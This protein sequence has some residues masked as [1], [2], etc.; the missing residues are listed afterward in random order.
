MIKKSLTP[1]LL[2]VALNSSVVAD[3]TSADVKTA[4]GK[5]IVHQEYLNAK[6]EQQQQDIATQKEEIKVLRES[7]KTLQ[8]A[9]NKPTYISSAKEAFSVADGLNIRADASISSKILNVIPKNTKVVVEECKPNKNN[10][11]WC[12]ISYQQGYIR[13][14]LL[15]FDKENTLNIEERK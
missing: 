6:L 5:M 8:E 1:F 13:S 3:I 2:I 10:E 14:F 4:L 12:K 9:G 15:S 11:E 7:I